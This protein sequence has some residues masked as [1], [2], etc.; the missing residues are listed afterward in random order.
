MD[1]HSFA[2]LL[3]LWAIISPSTRPGMMIATEIAYLDASI[4][5]DQ[6]PSQ[7]EQYLV[8][9]RLKATSIIPHAVQSSS[10]PLLP[11]PC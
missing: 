9:L 2:C 4:R 10:L 5:P 7:D 6:V 8:A 11:N 1:L 3:A